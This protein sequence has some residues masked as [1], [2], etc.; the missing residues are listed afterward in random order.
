MWEGGDPPGS[1]PFF[2]STTL[3]VL[4]SFLTQHEAQE[5]PL[6]SRGNQSNGALFVAVLF[7]CFFVA[8]NFC[9]WIC[10]LVLSHRIHSRVA[11][12]G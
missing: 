7:P 6:N 9:C 11:I 12:Y 5:W 1:A 10:C 2:H 4:S 3:E 8:M